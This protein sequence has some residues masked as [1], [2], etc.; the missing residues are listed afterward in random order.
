LSNTWILG[1]AAIVTASYYGWA[2]RTLAGEHW[3]VLATVPRRRDEHGEWR[4][5]N[6]TWYGA[7]TANAYVIAVAAFLVLMTTLQVPLQPLLIVVGGTLAICVPASRWM[8]RVIDRKPFGFTVAGAYT[9]GA[10][11]MP[12]LALMCNAVMGEAVIPIA[13][14]LAAAGVAFVL[15]EGIGRLACISFGCCYGVP[16]KDCP[17]LV[18]RLIGPRSFRFTGPTKKASY[19]GRLEG[20]PLVPI[21]AITTV[22]LTVTAFAAGMLFL[23]GWYRVSFVL[24]VVLSQLWR[25]AS[26]WLRADD[27]GAGRITAYQWMALGLVAYS[28]AA[29][30]VLSDDAAPVL[31]LSAA[32]ATFWTP[33]PLLALQALWAVIFLYTGRS[34]TTAA[35]LRLHV[36]QDRI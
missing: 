28:V 9:V 5:V 1:L 34:Q 20:V 29:A 19:E 10:V 26:E 31:G 6:F 18:R 23:G 13:P 32:L 12:P 27:R 14:L 33:G 16:L 35:T 22:V 15:G 36:C 17:A 8:S 30:F 25:F 2:F 4:G 24:S 21:Q 3:Q 7:L 11:V